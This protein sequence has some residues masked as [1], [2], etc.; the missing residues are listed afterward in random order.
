MADVIS[1]D[2]P[3]TSDRQPFTYQTRLEV[4]EIADPLPSG[5][6]QDGGETGITCDA[7]CSTV[8]NPRALPILK[9]CPLSAYA[10]LF[11]RAERVLFARICAGEYAHKLKTPMAEEFGLTARQFNAMR[12][13]LDGK[14][15]AIKK[16]QRAAIESLQQRIKRLEKRQ[17][18]LAK[19]RKVEAR[20][21][22]WIHQNNR[23]LDE[24]NHQLEK[25][26]QEA[27]DGKI[28]LCFGS[29][30]LFHRQFDP[31]ENGYANHQAW[32]DDWQQ[33]RSSQFMVIG[34]KDESGGN[35]TCT[36]TIEEDGSLTLRLRM[37]DALVA[38]YGKYVIFRQVRFAYGHDEVCAALRSCEERAKRLAA[39]DARAKEYGQAIQYRFCEDDKGWRVFATVDVPKTPT[40]TSEKLGAIGID[41]NADHVAVTELDRFGN[42]V[43]THNFPMVTY[44]KSTHQAEAL[45]GDVCAAVV[46]FAKETGKPLVH[47]E[48]DFTK[49]KRELSENESP[50][51]ARMLSGFAYQQF[52]DTLQSRSWREGVD[53]HAVNPA[54]TSVIGRV[55]F[56]TRYGLTIHQ[57]AACVIGRR[58][59]GLSER[60]PRHEGPIPDGKGSHV[61]VPLPVRKRGMHVW[62]FWAALDRKLKTALAAH[63]WATLR[64]S[65][66]PPGACDSTTMETEDVGETPARESVRKTARRTS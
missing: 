46:A 26:L 17:R 18:C 39:G 23:K 9:P 42:P 11:S 15:A 66:R 41:L 51:Y 8:G 34:S 20:A 48:L 43:S 27:E 6:T 65:S 60:A 56:A 62:K 5:L 47:E 28:P 12:V 21:A 1:T 19:C 4:V 64:R 36:A 49:K 55:K 10:E 32:L 24:L 37:P 31:E 63:F 59:F 16:Q 22:L 50:R 40:V 45:I 52:A 53:L 54:Y 61:T 3:M 30:R 35:Q 25:L 29:R 38:Q 57:A 14:I 7:R 13:E 33:R 2:G 44:G 58:Y